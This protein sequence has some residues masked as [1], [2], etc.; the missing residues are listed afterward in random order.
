MLINARDKS[1]DEWSSWYHIETLNFFA[2]LSFLS[3]SSSSA[4]I[5]IMAFH[6]I[7]VNMGHF[8]NLPL[9]VICCRTF[10]FSIYIDTFNK[11][12]L[13]WRNLIESTICTSTI[14]HTVSRRIYLK[15]KLERWRNLRRRCC[16]SFFPTSIILRFSSWLYGGGYI[17]E[18]KDDRWRKSRNIRRN[19]S[20]PFPREMRGKEN[21]K[22]SKS[23]LDVKWS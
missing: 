21:T 3:S 18:N 12:N 8:V 9:Y 11:Y 19:Y 17:Q 7:N 23:H 20:Q 6:L 1:L 15:R 5:F 22:K 2:C 13:E 10:E 14:Q 16:Y 4:L